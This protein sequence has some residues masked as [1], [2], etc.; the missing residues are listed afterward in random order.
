VE[1]SS[2]S[3]IF[4]NKRLLMIKDGFLYY[5]SNVPADYKTHEPNL[6]GSLKE[7]PKCSIEIRSIQTI[8]LESAKSS[9][10]VITFYDKDMIDR[11]D[12]R[13][14]L[15]SKN[16][17]HPVKPNRD[18][19]EEWKFIFA[20]VMKCRLWYG[21]LVKLKQHFVKSQDKFDKFT[22]YMANFDPQIR[23]SLPQLANRASA[24]INLSSPTSVSAPNLPA[25]KSP[26]R[27]S[28]TN[29][30]EGKYKMDKE[31]GIF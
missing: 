14:S 7:F 20:T 18:D 22:E 10:L 31:S 8:K 12:I 25:P 2:K 16:Y 21:S 4:T 6:M 29:S 15:S 3:G 28:N 23:S 27:Q 26:T 19:L 11:E 13:K 5:F 30:P 9:T 24:P 1:K 17:N